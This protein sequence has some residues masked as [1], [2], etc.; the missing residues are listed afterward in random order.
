MPQLNPNPWLSTMIMA[1]LTLSLVIQPK[2]LS[3]T[4]TNPLTNKTALTTKANPWT[5]PWS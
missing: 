2:V 5:W 3:F 1:W 4:P